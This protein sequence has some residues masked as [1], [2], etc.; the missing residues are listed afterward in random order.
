VWA[1]SICQELAG[2]VL[3]VSAIETASQHGANLETASRDRVNICMPELI[4]LLKRKGDEMLL[5]EAYPL[6]LKFVPE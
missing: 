4:E 3:L 1:G 5:Y 6:L 2:P